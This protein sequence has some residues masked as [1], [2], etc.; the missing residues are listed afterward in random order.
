[1]DTAPETT[2]P[3]KHPARSSLLAR[4][5][6]LEYLTIGYNALEALIAVSAGV[7]AGS[8]ALIGFGLDSVIEI[9]AGATLLWRL[10]QETRIG[11]EISEEEHSALERRALLIIGLTFFALAGYIAIEAGYKLLTGGGAEE[12]TVGIILAAASLIIMPLLAL[13]K[14][15]TARGLGSKALAAD[16]METWICSYLSLVLLAGLGLNAAFDWG[17]ADPLAAL[18]MLPLIIKEGWE[19]FE[20]AREE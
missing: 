20:E 6:A 13:L 14:T 10:K 9:A 5:I 19:A 15:R 16:A 3:D 12:S 11:A 8:V 4:G 18:A 17:W 2:A 7:I 1:M